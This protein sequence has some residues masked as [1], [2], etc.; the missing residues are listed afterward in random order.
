MQVELK[1]RRK[2][3]ECES[4]ELVAQHAPL[5]KAIA[6]SLLRKLPTSVE[7]DDLMQD[8]YIGLLG[9]ILQTTKENA[10]GHVR[11]YLTQRIRG[12]MLDGL[13]ENDPG[14]RKIRRAMR[15]VEQAIHELGHRLGRAPNETEIAAALE[16]PLAT[17][18]RLLQDA[19][20]YTLFSIEDFDGGDATANYLE[21]CVSTASDPMAALERR[22]LQRRL[23]IAMGD[24]SSREG[25]VMSF[26]YVED[27]GMKAVGARLGLSE[28]RISQIHA[29][30]IAKL[31]AAVIGPEEHPSLLAPRRRAAALQQA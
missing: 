1:Q 16:M 21:W 4:E 7:L 11:Q 12:A 25:E 9:A 29:Q 3:T 10:G 20:G 24:L 28:G 13:R 22:V 19:H 14:T 26:L 30:A 5:V 17:Y 27:M 31:R 2:L 15:A 18:H 23:L 6:Q 8:G